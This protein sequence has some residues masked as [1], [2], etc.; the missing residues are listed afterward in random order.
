MVMEMD[1][2]VWKPTNT[3]DI[4]INLELY[5]LSGCF[6][7]R[8]SLSVC[9]SGISYLGKD[10]L[11]DHETFKEIFN[12][13]LIYTFLKMCNLTLISKFHLMRRERLTFFYFLGNSFS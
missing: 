11:N 10:I 13:F 9:L 7:D 6:L 2:M 8:K 4:N 1:K 3:V 12:V 5:L